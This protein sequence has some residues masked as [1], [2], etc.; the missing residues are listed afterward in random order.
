MAMAKVRRFYMLFCEIRTIL[1]LEVLGFEVFVFKTPVVYLPSRKQ[2]VI[3]KKVTTC[4]NFKKKFRCCQ[5]HR[6]L[7]NI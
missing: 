5:H 2:I 6:Q 4:F 7:H 1:V 3:F